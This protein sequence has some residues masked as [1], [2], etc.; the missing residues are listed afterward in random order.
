[1]PLGF[2]LVSGTPVVCCMLFAYNPNDLGLF[3]GGGG[4]ISHT[5]KTYEISFS[6]DSLGLVKS[7]GG[8]ISLTEQT[9]IATADY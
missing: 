4:V 9:Y 6:T 7:K 8:V 3:K 2:I 1:M 5:D